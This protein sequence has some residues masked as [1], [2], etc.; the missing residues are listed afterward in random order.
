MTTRTKTLAGASLVLAF[1]LTG[2]NGTAGNGEA[3]TTSAA[4]SSTSQAPTETSSSASASQSSSVSATSSQPASSGSAAS[5]S[6]APSFEPVTSPQPK[7]DQTAQIKGFEALQRLYDIQNAQ[8][9]GGSVDKE[10]LAVAVRE[11]YLSKLA[12]QMK[13]IETAGQSYSGKSKIELLEPIIGPT[14]TMKGD[15]TQHANAQLRVCEDNTGVVVKDKDGKRVSSGSALRYEITY[16][17]TW[18]PDD[19]AWKVTTRDVERDEKGNPT[20]C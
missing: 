5:S 11:P 17:V 14:S 3:S 13:P 7:D 1:A 4:S 6:S 15:L 10:Q 20:T 19:Q 12:E 8:F 16:I 2:C 18:E 9:V